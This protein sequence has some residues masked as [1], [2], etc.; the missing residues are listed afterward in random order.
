MLVQVKIVSAPLV[1][2]G[3]IF[4]TLARQ[5]VSQDEEYAK[6][7]A[8]KGSVA[9]Y[10]HRHS[11]PALQLATLPP[12]YYD[13]GDAVHRPRGLWV[14]LSSKGKA[15]VKEGNHGL[16]FQKLYINPSFDLLRQL[17]RWK[18]C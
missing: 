14:P 8:K 13:T 2:K 10:K 1:S 9:S 12:R 5:N 6:R 15:K 3:R 7:K 17:S 11:V 4:T 18:N 16:A